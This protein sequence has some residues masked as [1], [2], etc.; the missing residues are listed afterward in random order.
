VVQ[1][2]TT[3]AERT[4]RA[5]L[6]DVPERIRADGIRPP[7]IIVIGPVAEFETLSRL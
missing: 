1:H 7:A 3:A 4:L 5:T 2:G 6:S